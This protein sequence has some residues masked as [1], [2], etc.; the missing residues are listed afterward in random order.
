MGHLTAITKILL[1][2]CEMFGNLFLHLLQL[3]RIVK[4]MQ[5]NRLIFLFVLHNH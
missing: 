5:Q 1:E 4:G 2:S 3:H